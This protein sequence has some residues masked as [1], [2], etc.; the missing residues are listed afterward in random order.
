MSLRFMPNTFKSAGYL[1]VVENSSLLLFNKWLIINFNVNLTI[2][3][4][5]K[6]HA[7]DLP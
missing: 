6:L 4:S 7:V 2:D 5:A 1:L 3:R